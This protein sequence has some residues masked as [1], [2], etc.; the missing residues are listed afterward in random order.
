MA[1]DAD[2][3]ASALAA[4]WQQFVG[5][6]PGWAKREGGVL[7]A[8]SGVALANCNGVWAEQVEPDEDLVAALL[9]EV[10]TAQLP[11][12]LQLRPG[13]SLALTNLPGGRGM[14]LDAQVPLMVL[15]GSGALEAARRVDG[16]EIRELTPEAVQEHVTIA[17]SGFGAPE[18]LM[19]QLA[20]PALLRVPGVR[21]YVGE[22]DGH[23]VTTGVGLTLH[24]FVGIF[25][26]A[27]PPRY[28]GQGYAGAVT[29][30]AVADGL[31]DGAE[32]AWLQSSPAGYPIYTRLGFK[33]VERWSS[34]V[35]L[36]PHG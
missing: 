13:A 12:C 14:V 20:T 5:A 24:R 1:V 19:A 31:S 28:R 34:W 29:A 10:A 4:S 25:S 2:T 11:Y 22:V 16:L 30:R 8:M 27:T 36:A 17:A 23:P 7:A 15:E 35:S 32:W 26:I 33:T 6:M 9:N 21:C 18:D 3:A